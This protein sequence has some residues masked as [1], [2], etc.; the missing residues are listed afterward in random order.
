M[1]ESHW[2][3]GLLPRALAVGACLVGAPAL[4]AEGKDVL[5]SFGVGLDAGVPDFAGLNLV[6]RPVP[7]LRLQGGP[8][9]NGAG[10][11]VRGGV[12]LV[13]FSTVVAPSLTLEYGHYFSSDMRSPLGSVGLS[14]G[15][16]EPVLSK[17]SYGFGSAH[18]GLEVGSARRFQFFLRAGL[19]YVHTTLAGSGELIEQSAGDSSLSAEDFRL[20][21]VLPSVKLGV[22]FYFG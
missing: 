19:S 2:K 20:R 6:Y 1:S 12:S 9:F 14:L 7:F 22:L 8:L 5:P 21:G 16:A 13:P 18:L 11:G 3:N 4:A 15:Q 17:L 10:V